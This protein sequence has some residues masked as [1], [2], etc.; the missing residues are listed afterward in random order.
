ML[1]NNVIADKEDKIL[2]YQNLIE[3]TSLKASFPSLASEV[4]QSSQLGCHQVFH[5]S[6]DEVRQI[7]STNCHTED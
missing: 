5:V 3:T 6:F 7:F 4:V 1:I 2:A